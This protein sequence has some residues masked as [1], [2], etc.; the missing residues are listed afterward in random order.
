M[1]FLL[2]KMQVD[3]ESKIV[4]KEEMKK[5]GAQLRAS[6]EKVTE[7]EAEPRAPH[8]RRSNGVMRCRHPSRNSRPDFYL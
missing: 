4:T 3:E 6:R 8:I 5:M 2:N 1:N 7:L